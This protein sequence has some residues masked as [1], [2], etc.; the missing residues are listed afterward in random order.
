MKVPDVKFQGNPASWSSA[1]TNADG[2]ADIEE[3]IPRLKSQKNGWW[4]DNSDCPYTG[5]DRP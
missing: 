3:L 4:I 2:R 5:L 1:D